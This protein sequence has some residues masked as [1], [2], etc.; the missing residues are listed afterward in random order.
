[1]YI[2][3]SFADSYNFSQITLPLLQTMLGIIMYKHHCLYVYFFISENADN[4]DES[5]NENKQG[6]S[7]SLSPAK[8][9]SPE[10]KTER[11]ERS[12]SSPNKQVETLR[13]EWSLN[14]SRVYYDRALI[15]SFLLKGWQK[16]TWQTPTT[17]AERPGGWCWDYSESLWRWLWVSHFEEGWVDGREMS[18]GWDTLADFISDEKKE[19]KDTLLNILPHR[20]AAQREAIR[21]E[22]R[23]KFDSV[24]WSL[25][26][27]GWITRICSTEMLF[28][29]FHRI[30]SK[31]LARGCAGI[32]H[33]SNRA[34]RLWLCPQLNTT[35]KRCETPW[36]DLAQ[37]RKNWMRFS[38]HA[39]E[40]SAIFHLIFPLKK[41]GEISL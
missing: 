34:C 38:S 12:Q 10:S 8:R 18:G 4:D 32:S 36:E 6:R 26:S 27:P 13:H 9:L 37:T 20:T 5:D 24:E 41:Y 15:T 40:M 25:P 35:C 7:R 16:F 28:R 1:M 17:R 29:V 33:R 11:K 22:Y 39:T 19:F 21:E 2:I 14:Q 31:M 23:D 3:P 30:C